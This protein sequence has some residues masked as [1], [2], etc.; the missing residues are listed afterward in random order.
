MAAT[1][2]HANYVAP[3]G[4]LAGNLKLVP[5]VVSFDDVALVDESEKVIGKLPAGALVVGGYLVTDDLDVGTEVLEIDYGWAANGAVETDGY[6]DPYGVVYTNSGYQASQTGFIDS[7]ALLGDA[8]AGIPV[9]AG[10]NYRQILLPKPLFFKSETSV[11]QHVEVPANTQAAGNA[12]LYLA[13][14]LP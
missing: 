9:P 8:V 12:T 7:A 11:V 1:A 5:F 13:Y 4:G 10:L 3:T 6:T 2:L 14:I